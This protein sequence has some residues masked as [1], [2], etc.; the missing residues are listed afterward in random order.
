IICDFDVQIAFVKPRIFNTYYFLSGRLAVD[1]PEGVTF[2]S[3]PVMDTKG[4]SGT[5]WGT[6]DLNDFNPLT[7]LDLN[8]DI[9]ELKI[10]NSSMDPDVPFFGNV[11]G[12]G[13]FRLSGSNTNMNLRSPQAI[14]LTSD[15]HISL[16]L[17]DETELNEAGK[18][19]RFVD[20]FENY[21]AGDQNDRSEKIDKDVQEEQ[22]R[23]QISSLTFSERFNLDLRFTTANTIAVS[24]IFDPVTGDV[25]KA[26][27]SGQMRIAMQGQDLQM[28]GRY[29]ITSGTY[30]FVTGEIISRKLELQPGGRIVWEGQPDNARLDI[31]AV[32]HA[33]PNISTL[34]G[35]GSVSDQNNVGRS[36]QV[37]V[38]LVVEISGTLNSV[39]NSYYFKLP[40]SLDLST[41]STLTYTINQIN[42]DDQQKLL[43]AT[44]ILFTGQFIPT[45]GGE[46]ATSSLSQNLTRGSTVLNPLLSNQVISPLL[47]NQ[48]N[49]LL[50]SDVS[51]LDIEFNL[52][53]Y[54][55]VDLGIALRLYN[56][57]LIL[58][59]EG[60]ITGGGPQ[61]TLGQRIGDLNATYRI[62]RR[63]SLTAFHR[64]NQ[65]LSDFGT[66]TQGGDVTPSLDGLGLEANFQFNTW[67]ELWNTIWGISSN[68]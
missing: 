61:T 18:F 28:F 26:R 6:I 35:G 68:S 57:R 27:G 4:G 30:Q 48:I 51:R 16:P 39:E 53:A 52:N 45:Q 55:E 40:S 38:D 1:R 50:N 56:D 42:R 29:R 5:L 41:N 36:Q 67:R 21:N 58:R 22:L 3:L 46:S 64:Q 62:S 66:Q 7:Y 31:S 32:Y 9:N 65:I 10:L 43:Q 34:A 13:R 17:M 23:E 20:S 37:P 8:F 11:S 25:L 54:N 33:R 60:Q 2:D 47:S 19:I 12:T 59:R 63:L 14:R 49:A 24:L 44:S 15:S